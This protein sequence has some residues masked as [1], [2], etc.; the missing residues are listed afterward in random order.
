MKNLIWLL[1]LLPLTLLGAQSAH[2]QTGP[3]YSITD[4]FQ[5]LTFADQALSFT[6][7]P[8]KQDTGIDYY[9]GCCGAPG[10]RGCS[11][12]FLDPL[13]SPVCLPVSPSL[14]TDGY[15]SLPICS[16]PSPAF[17][18]R[19]SAIPQNTSD[20]TFYVTSD[21]HYFR[22][23]YNLGD[24]LTHVKALNRFASL[25]YDWPSTTG[26]PAGTPILEPVAVIVNGDITTHGQQQDL[27]AFRFN[28]ES[29]TNGGS[30]KYPML[31]GLGNH[32]I[33]TNVVSSNDAHRMF[34][35]LQQR[36][37]N[38]R[39]S[40]SGN[41]SWDWNG[42]HMVQLNTWAGDQ[43]SHYTHPEGLSWLRSDLAKYVGNSTA[44][45]LI[46]QHYRLQDVGTNPSTYTSSGDSSN[47]GSWWPSDAAATDRNGNL[48][49]AGYESFFDIVSN[50][51]VIGMFS[52]H[53]H[54]L[55][56]SSTDGTSSNAGPASGATSGIVDLMGSV[57]PGI[58]GYGQPIDNYDDGSG[59]AQ[60]SANTNAHCDKPAVGN[61]L[62]THVNHH[63]LDVAAVSWE[64]DGSSEYFDPS[65]GFPNKMSAACRK[66]I[67][68]QFIAVDPS[69]ATLSAQGNSYQATNL[70][71]QTID[72]PLALQFPST[73]VIPPAYDFVDR[74][75]DGQ[76]SAYLLVNG[77]NS[78]GARQTETLN[79]PYSVGSAS[80]KL[81][82]L[83]PLS[84][85]SQ[86]TFLHTTAYAAKGM[87][88]I[89][90]PNDTI[91]VYGP[92]N[93][94][95]TVDDPIYQTSVTGW[96]Q[97]TPS[98]PNFDSLGRATVTLTYLQDQ[99]QETNEANAIGQI[100]IRTHGVNTVQS[101]FTEVDFRAPVYLTLTANPPDNGAVG[102]DPSVLATQ[103]GCEPEFTAHA[104]YD[105]ITP[106]GSTEASI[107]ITGV[108]NLYDVDP[109]T[110]AK[111]SLSTVIVNTD[112]EC[113]VDGTN[114]N[115]PVPDLVVFGSPANGD[116]IC[117]SF[118]PNNTPG[119]IDSSHRFVSANMAP[120]IYHLVV[121]YL[122]SGVA[123]NG[124]GDGLYAP[125]ISSPPLLYR[126]G[127]APASASAY[128][129]DGQTT[130]AGEFF[131]N[132]VAV[133]VWTNTLLAGGPTNSI[134]TFTAIP[135]SGGAS[136]SFNGSSS[137]VVYADSHG[138]A[139]TPPILASDVQGTWQISAAVTGL[140]TPVV[141][142]MT[143]S[144]PTLPNL[145]LMV[146]GKSGTLPNRTWTM[147]L[148][149]AGGTAAGLA[150]LQSLTFQQ[151]S[152]PVCNP[153]ATSLPYTDPLLS[154]IP[155]QNTVSFPVS[156]S[157]PSCSQ[158]SR[159]NVTAN[160][161]INSGKVSQQIVLANQFP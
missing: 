83:T 137:V 118:G 128:A 74:C 26:I 12:G 76:Y 42:V 21:I 108:L 59:G 63:Y 100:N 54:C 92:A 88:A 75:G 35:Y 41:Y 112:N 98:G 24:Q 116:K 154:A 161:L 81:V 48:T 47:Q 121:A 66:R 29:G 147:E 62:V 114:Y 140:T 97:A 152:G 17:D 7:T 132:Q 72:V 60:G 141:F 87:T 159:F 156:I 143:N 93:K 115:N 56:V 90:P 85:L 110:G 44:P 96:L 146:T 160:V 39:M 104:S 123:G 117:P 135:G 139:T 149:N 53:D 89:A 68:S 15:A 86:S 69:I 25:G 31:F 99:L 3:G 50:Y 6:C 34:D 127:D 84:G 105:H 45:V 4:P 111:N 30:L 120:G 148:V 77:E 145:Q 157:F 8:Q 91:T 13:S 51:N 5:I 16:L 144:I 138:I 49:G 65:I 134:V 80:P 43:M 73:G 38:T 37:A 23:D 20:I 125:A 158:L 18:P 94:P 22:T 27:G 79:L 78:L 52:G 2:A 122:G 153:S 106:Q 11:A 36:M 124:Q 119:Q 142:T 126:I 9:I 107:F 28:Y 155:G 109:V 133:K 102:C 131:N 14:H 55:G 136:G 57:F 130:P 61:F 151:K 40:S 64:G 10:R 71:G 33:N 101:V 1:L 67:N 150:T 32:D 113:L 103:P 82:A 129:G 70:T 58:P 19:V 46:F 95:F